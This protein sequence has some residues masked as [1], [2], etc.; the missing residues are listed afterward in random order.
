MAEAAARRGAR[1]VLVSGPTHLPPPRGVTLRRVESAGDMY[2][3]VWEIRDQT[4]IFVLAAAVSDLTFPEASTRKIKKG[5][6]GDSLA[7]TGTKDILRSLGEKKA[8]KFLVGFAAETEELEANAR[9]KLAA[10]NCDLIVA[11][12]V[13]DPHIGFGSEANQVSIYSA[14]GLLLRTE[15][16]GKAEI[17]AQIWDVIEERLGKKA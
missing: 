5:G 14:A 9:G 13:S 4:D 10:K 2:Q 16:A 12:D 11:N 3:A 17:A 7:V 6:L 15:R 1:V 8:G